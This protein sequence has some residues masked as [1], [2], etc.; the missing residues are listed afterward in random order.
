M[1]GGNNIQLVDVIKV[2]KPKS[3]VAD[4]ITKGTFFLSCWMTTAQI[5]KMRTKKAMFE[6]IK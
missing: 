5:Q 6:D 2:E 3:E 1:L 4:K